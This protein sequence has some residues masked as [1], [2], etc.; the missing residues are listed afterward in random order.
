M[1]ETLFFFLSATRAKVGFQL[2]AEFLSG[3]IAVLLVQ[4]AAPDHVQR[5]ED[6]KHKSVEAHCWHSPEEDARKDQCRMAETKV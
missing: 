5:E 6:G 3:V 4:S 1:K 2:A